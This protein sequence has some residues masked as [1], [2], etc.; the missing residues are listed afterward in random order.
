MI[1]S[2]LLTVLIIVVVVLGWL[3]FAL[4]I[5]LQKMDKTQAIMLGWFD[6]IQKNEETLQDDIK[7]IFYEFKTIGKEIGKKPRVSP[8]KA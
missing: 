2:I 5:K 4:H 3:V 6:G 7:K 8:P 1:T